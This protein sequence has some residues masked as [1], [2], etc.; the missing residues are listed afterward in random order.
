M[1]NMRMLHFSR[2]FIKV[3]A[4]GFT[5]IEI[6][7]SLMI[8]GLISGLLLINLL[9]NNQTRLA[10][11]TKRLQQV[12]AVA[13]DFSK[14]S[15]LRIAWVVGN[16]GTNYHFEMESVEGR[17][18]TYTHKGSLADTIRPYTYPTAI[19]VQSV[20]VNEEELRTDKKLLFDPSGMNHPFSLSLAIKDE[21][22]YSRTI[23]GDPL[24]RTYDKAE[25]Q[26]WESNKKAMR[27]AIQNQAN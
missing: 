21:P 10:D 20:M 22:R 9:P 27:A 15:G 5:F 23:V 17:W 13:A 16:A 3:S 8:L 6:L 25:M 2:Q 26:A 11:E 12:L 18:T 19:F 7:V 14:L 4:G 24:G 1:K